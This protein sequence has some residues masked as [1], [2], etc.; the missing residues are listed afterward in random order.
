MWKKN[1]EEYTEKTPPSVFRQLRPDST[2]TTHSSSSLFRLTSMVWSGNVQP[3]S[4]IYLCIYFVSVVWICFLF[5]IY[6]SCFEI[7]PAYCFCSAIVLYCHFLCTVSHRCHSSSL[8]VTVK[9][10]LVE[11]L[12]LMPYSETSHHPSFVFLNHLF[13]NRMCTPNKAQDTES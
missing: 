8:T 2:S 7:L 1:L 4:L 13:V 9:L 5:F 12:E 11:K 6:I 10:R 3:Q